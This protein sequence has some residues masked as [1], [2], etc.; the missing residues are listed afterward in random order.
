MGWSCRSEAGDT[1]DKWS[2]A[3]MAQT[4]S[5]NA[6]ESK[7]TRYFWELSRTEHHDGAIT[8]SVYKMVSATQCRR[9]STLRIEPNGQVSRA[10]AF[11]KQVAV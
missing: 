5:S 8:G 9:A 3:C 7:G 1:V 11:L 4:G 10:P 6:F 2:A